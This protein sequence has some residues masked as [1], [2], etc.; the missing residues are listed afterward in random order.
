MDRVRVDSSNIR[1]IGYDVQRQI[2]EIE[3]TNGGI[4]QYDGVPKSVYDR[5]MSSPS[6]GRFFSAHIRDKY[7]TRKIR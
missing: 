3:F 6:K 2:L 5:F 1:S 7:L 4:Y